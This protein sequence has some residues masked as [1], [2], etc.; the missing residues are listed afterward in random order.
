M[1]MQT[2]RKSKDNNKT[3]TISQAQ[4]KPI[5]QTNNKTT[6]T[7]D[8]INSNIR[9]KQRKQTHEHNTYIHQKQ[10]RPQQNN[11]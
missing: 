2:I 5:A 1:T 3:H 7:K 10:Q 8:T 11:V 4:D 6:T 9:N